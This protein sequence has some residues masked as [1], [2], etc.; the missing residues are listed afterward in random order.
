MSVALY[1]TMIAVGVGLFTWSY[2]RL[3]RANPQSTIPQ[4]FGR[5]ESHPLGL[6]LLRGAGIFLMGFGVF[7]LSNGL[8]LGPVGAGILIFVCMAIPGFAI[9]TR[10][11]LRVKRESQ[12]HGV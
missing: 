1:A 12:Q 3:T 10:H 11:N 4:W 5:P 2:V 9:V 8:E 7:L 6:H